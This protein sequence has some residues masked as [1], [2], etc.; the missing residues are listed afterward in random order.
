MSDTCRLY[1][2]RIS[3]RNL[4][5]QRIILRLPPGLIFQLEIASGKAGVTTEQWLI[6][7]A[8]EKLRREL[9]KYSKGPVRRKGNR[10]KTMHSDV[11]FFMK[12]LSQR[13][14]RAKNRK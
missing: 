3:A 12:I 14:S 2:K 10:N 8:F 4:R 7:A 5:P 11:D 6:I 13:K 9:F 1:I